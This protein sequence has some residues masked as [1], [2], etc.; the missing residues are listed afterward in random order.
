MESLIGQLGD[1]AEVDHALLVEIVQGARLEDKEKFYK[2][3]RLLDEARQEQWR[4]KPYNENKLGCF[5]ALR[6]WST[7]RQSLACG[8][9]KVC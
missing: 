1:G 5:R 8:I 2:A 7:H 3:G 6:F 9:R 4:S